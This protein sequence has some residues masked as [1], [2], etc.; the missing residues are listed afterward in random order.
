MV[1]RFSPIIIRPKIKHAH[2]IRHLTARCQNNHRRV[3]FS[4]PMLFQKPRPSPSGNMI[5]NSIRL[6][7]K[8]YAKAAASLIFAAWSIEWPSSLILEQMA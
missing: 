1:E 8:V 5:S 2:F 6:Y 3:I 4:R 7:S